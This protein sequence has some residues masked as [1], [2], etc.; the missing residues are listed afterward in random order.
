LTESVEPFLLLVVDLLLTDGWRLV[1][2]SSVISGLFDLVVSFLTEMDMF[3]SPF[4]VVSV[5]AA[6]VI[7]RSFS[8]LF[9]PAVAAEGLTPLLLLLL[10][11]VVALL[12]FGGLRGAWVG[13]D[14]RESRWHL[15]SGTWLVLSVESE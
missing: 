12:L 5:L 6:G 9:T 1:D 10:L 11:Y 3:R 4:V 7:R 14:M 15:S 13:R 8:V 2:F